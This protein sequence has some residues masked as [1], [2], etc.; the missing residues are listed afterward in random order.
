MGFNLG[1]VYFDRILYVVIKDMKG[2]LLSVANQVQNFAVDITA[3]SKDITDARGRLLKKL[4]TSKAGTITLTSQMMHLPT[5]AVAHGEDIIFAGQDNK[6]VIQD[7]MKIPASQTEVT[8]TGL[9]DNTLEVY[10]YLSNGATGKKY[11]LGTSASAKEYVVDEGKK[12]TLPKDTDAAEY[13]VLFKREV[14]SGAV[15]KNNSGK[16]PKTVEIG[17]FGLCGDPCEDERKGAY[18]VFPS[19][20]PSPEVSFDFQTDSTFEFKGDLQASYCSGGNGELYSIVFP[21]EVIEDD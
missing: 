10:E 1:N 21:D 9:V 6:V 7:Q 14:T 12:L 17:V 18:A 8:L 15:L 5:L 3:E 16:F 2:N 20:Q 11:T 4:Y 13:L 19:V